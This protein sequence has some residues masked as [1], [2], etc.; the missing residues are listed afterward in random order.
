MNYC[1]P[2]F[3]RAWSQAA[4]P[5][6]DLVAFNDSLEGM[7]GAAGDAVADVESAFSVTDVTLVDG[8][9]L[10]VVRRQVFR[11]GCPLEPLH[12]QLVERP[13]CDDLHRDGRGTPSASLRA[14]P[15]TDRGKTGIS[16]GDAERDQAERVGVSSVGDRELGVR[17]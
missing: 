15:I 11:C 3:P 2:G 4:C 5:L 6:A 10:D 14:E 16:L 13:A 8:T 12:A 7:Y 9:P 1:G 17:G